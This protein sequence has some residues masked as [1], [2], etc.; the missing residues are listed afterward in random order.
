MF[1]KSNILVV[2]LIIIVAVIAAD[3]KA[4]NYLEEIKEKPAGNA[5]TAS[6]EL[7]ANVINFEAAGVL[8]DE[9]HESEVF[10]LSDPSAPKI[11]FELI[12]RTGLANVSLQRV[13]FNGIMFERVDLRDFK[14]VPVLKT[15]LVENGHDPIGEFY[16]FHASSSLLANEIYLLIKE[17][18]GGSLES[19]VNETNDLGEKS[20][21]INYSDKK[22]TAFPVVKIGESVYALSYE[23]GLHSHMQTLIK[24]LSS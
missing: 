4:N 23:K 7:K 17:K 20:F 5:A 11:T 19:T 2:L 24:L 10:S 16:E 12:S 8:D 1:S 14:S 18:A 3:M 22:I 15:N 13:P 6:D 21:Y 9:K